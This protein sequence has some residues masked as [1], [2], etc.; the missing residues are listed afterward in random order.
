MTKIGFPHLAWFLACLITLF[1]ASGCR[2]FSDQQTSAEFTSGPNSS[3]QFID[4][5]SFSEIRPKDKTVHF[6]SGRVELTRSQ[7]GLSRIMEGSSKNS[8]ELFMDIRDIKGA[9]LYLADVNR[10]NQLQL[11][12][13]KSVLV[14]HVLG[15]GQRNDDVRTEQLYNMLI[16]GGVPVGRSELFYFA[17][18]DLTEQRT[19]NGKRGF[20]STSTG[21]VVGE[22]IW[23]AIKA[24]GSFL[25]SRFRPY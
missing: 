4:Q 18:M 10:S 17:G 21:V 13:E 1:S 15:G 16:A 14:V 11:K 2:S 22:I 20:L 6:T 23:G 12:Y 8:S 5:C 3:V 24:A 25:I 7:L 19:S 9:F